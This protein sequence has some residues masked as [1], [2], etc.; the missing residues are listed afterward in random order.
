[1]AKRKEISIEGESDGEMEED[2]HPTNPT[3]SAPK[4]AKAAR[5]K[6][7]TTITRRSRA[8]KVQESHD[9]TD[10]SHLL[11]IFSSMFRQHATLYLQEAAI[12]EKLAMYPTEPHLWFDAKTSSSTVDSTIYETLENRTFRD[13]AYKL[14]S[15]SFECLGKMQMEMDALQQVVECAMQD[16]SD[17][18]D[19]HSG[20]S[21]VDDSTFDF[22]IQSNQ[23]NNM[24]SFIVNEQ[25]VEEDDSSTNKQFTLQAISTT[26]ENTIQGKTRNIIHRARDRDELESDD[27]DD[28]DDDSI[29][30]F[31]QHSIHE[32]IEL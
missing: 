29:S 12:L 19:D 9:D 7:T 10:K 26:K 17:D 6:S 11:N 16:R 3:I 27:D 25:E 22:N 21:S 24:N 31:S 32:I 8:R 4:T 1:M 20:D 30:N 28:D 15:K 2:I 14:A 13:N 18:D 23:K 5:Q